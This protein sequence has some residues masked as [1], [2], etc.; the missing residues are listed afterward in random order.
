MELNV[1]KDH[2]HL[3]LMIRPKVSISDLMGRLKGQ[4]S[5]K[6]FNQFRELR[7]KPYWGNHFWAKGYCVDTIGLDADMIRKYVRYQE[8]KE[9]QVEQLQLL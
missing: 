4:T 6:I 1:Q 8:G 9:K 5:M 3:V 7:K 2:V